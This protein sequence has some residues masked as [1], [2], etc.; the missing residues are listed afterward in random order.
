MQVQ[1]WLWRILYRL[2]G[3]T[4]ITYNSIQCVNWLLGQPTVMTQTHSF[5]WYVWGLE[6]KNNDHL[7]K[8][9]HIGIN[10]IFQSWHTDIE[11]NVWTRMS[12]CYV[13]TRMLFWS[14]TGGGGGGKQFVT[15]AH[16][17]PHYCLVGPNKYWLIIHQVQRQSSEGHFIRDTP[18]SI[19]S[20]KSPLTHCGLVTPFGDRYLGQ[21]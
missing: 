15:T 9:S 10:D 12:N 5:S 21:H 4:I 17:L 3:V 18:P 16:S 13:I 1:V 7:W 6:E 11:N 8:G 20:L 2:K 19:K 14:I